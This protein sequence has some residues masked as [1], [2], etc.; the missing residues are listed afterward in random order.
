MY[1][2]PDCK[3]ELPATARFCSVCGSRTNPQLMVVP[4]TPFQRTR[5]ETSL[6]A[7]KDVSN[8]PLPTRPTLPVPTRAIRTNIR[9]TLP[10]RPSQSLPSLS[11]LPTS[12]LGNGVPLQTGSPIQP[13]QQQDESASSST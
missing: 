4:V 8:T 11:A 7:S 1:Q 12:P 5:S 3:T 13:S 10:R 6:G 9:Q 2:C